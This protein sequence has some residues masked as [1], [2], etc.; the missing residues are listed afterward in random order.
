MDAIC[1]SLIREVLDGFCR[2]T[3][4][5]P[6]TAEARAME[7]SVL[8]TSFEPGY[9]NLTQKQVEAVSGYAFLNSFSNPGLWNETGKVSLT[10]TERQEG[11]AYEEEIR[12]GSRDNVRT[13]DDSRDHHRDHG[14]R[15]PERRRR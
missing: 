10:D 7:F 2:D 3:D 6:N 14:R 1:I 11:Q 4:G 12:G 8:D 13:D 5:M 15:A 9:R